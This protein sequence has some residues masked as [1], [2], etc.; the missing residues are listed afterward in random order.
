MLTAENL[1]RLYGY[2]LVQ[3]ERADANGQMQRWFVPA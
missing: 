1:S 2:P 3:I